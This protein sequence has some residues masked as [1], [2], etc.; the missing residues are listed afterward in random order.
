MAIAKKNSETRFKAIRDLK[1][2]LKA[3]KEDLGGVGLS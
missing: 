2:L 3:E 1:R